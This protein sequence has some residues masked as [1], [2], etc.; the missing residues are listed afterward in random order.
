MNHRELVETIT[1]C[2]PAL[3]EDIRSLLGDSPPPLSAPVSITDTSR[4]LASLTVGERWIHS[5]RDP[6]REAQRLA[7]HLSGDNSATEGAEATLFFGFGLGY[8]VEAASA[9]PRELP[10]PYVAVVMHPAVLDVALQHRSA[11]WW[12][13]YGPDRLLPGWLPGV[14]A[15]VLQDSQIRRFPVLKTTGALQAFPDIAEAFQTALTRFQERTMVNRNTLNRFGRLWVR[16]TLQ[17]LRRYGIIPGIDTLVSA[18]PGIPALVCGAGPTLDDLIPLLPRISQQALIIATDTAVVALERWGIT[19]DFA[20]ISDPQYWNTRHLDQVS[21]FSAVLIAEPATHPRTLRLWNG[22]RAV[23]ASLFPLGSF[24][25]ARSGRST[26]LG[27]GGS[28][29][30]SAWD[31]ARVLG[32]RSIGLAGVDLGFPGYRTHC[33]GS[34]FE[35]RLALH[36]HRLAPAE[37]GLYGYLHGAKAEKV[38]SHG[39]DS[40]PSDARMQVYRSWFEEQNR[41]YPQVDTVLLS[42]RSSRIAGLSFQDPEEWLHGLQGQ[43]SPSEGLRSRWRRAFSPEHH[44]ETALPLLRELDSS[45]RSIFD[46]AQEGLRLCRSLLAQAL[47]EPSLLH[48]LPQLDDIDRKIAALE[49]RELAGFIA[50]QVIDD[51]TATRPSS[52]REAVIQA[53]QIYQSLVDATEFHRR[54]L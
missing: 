21:T 24:F 13:D 14:L 8:S 36:G 22:P 5:S 30:T 29:A 45:L 52:A 1:R 40:I 53:Q 33:A 37:T 38:A 39:G 42:S 18:A 16:N 54:L 20:V 25:D 9:H 34:F 23:S 41:R 27:A 3:A 31:L 10:R 32:A 35:R 43:P 12:C 6:Q 17:S 46:V 7:R 48:R 44:P 11:E 2:R 50:G 49:E 19:I 51:H 26:K 15:P 28:V 47:D 4:G